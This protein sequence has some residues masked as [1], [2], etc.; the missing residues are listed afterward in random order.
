M[1]LLVPGT[2][3]INLIDI[4]FGSDEE[5]IKDFYHKFNQLNRFFLEK[6]IFIFPD[7][8]QETY[9]TNLHLFT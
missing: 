2:F 7:V 6:N 3:E 1:V 5:L 8:N 4:I 9:L